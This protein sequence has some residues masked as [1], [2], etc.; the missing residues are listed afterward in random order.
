MQGPEQLLRKASVEKLSSP[1]QLDMMMRVTSPMG[2]VALCAIGVLI[3]VAIVWSITFPMPVKVDGR[4]FMVRGEAVQ[5]V[6][7]LTAGTLQSV[8]VKTGDIIEPGTVVAKVSMPDIEARL[9][10]ARALLGELEAQT[11][12]SGSQTASIQGRLRAQ[13]ARLE[14]DRRQKQEL[15]NRGLLTS[16]AVASIDQQITSLQNSL[17]QSM[18]GTGDRG[19]RVEDKR[20]EVRELETKLANESVVRSP[21]GGRVVAVRAGAG[22]P[23]R[24]GDALLSLEST[25]EPMRVVGFVPL[26]AGKQVTP[27]LEVRIAPS[28]IRVEDYGFMVGKVVSVSTLPATPEEIQRIV[29]NDALARQYIDLNPF[30]VVIEPVLAETPSGFRWTSSAGPPVE[31]G[32][33]TDCTVQVVVETRKPISYVI[34]T[35]KQTLGLS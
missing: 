22:Q 17:A 27:G 26:A 9:I 24:P 1:E 28:F 19:L 34:P 20:L 4:G 31:V 16:A 18:I 3:V 10:S 6:Q 29:A 14:Q 32:S 5:E 2:W 23:V 21:F 15:V 35:V 8:E 25:R 13:I 30:Q 12:S 33:G 7:I 11:S